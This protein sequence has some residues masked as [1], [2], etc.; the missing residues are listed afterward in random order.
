MKKCSKNKLNINMAN[1]IRLLVFFVCLASILL[2]VNSIFKFKYTDGISQLS[3]F[4]RQDRNSIDVLILGS[5]HSFV[6]CN[7]GTLYE[8]YGIASYNMG[9]SMQPMW[10]SYYNLIEALKTQKPE[11]I[12]LE[13]HGITF[14]FD[15][16]YTSAAIKNIY[17]MKWSLNKVRDILTSVDSD[18]RFDFIL[19]YS[20][21]H[22][23]YSSLNKGDFIDGFGD[24]ELEYAYNWYGDS[25]KGQYLF[26]TSN[27]IEIEDVSDVDGV[28][29]LSSKSEM[30]YRKIIELAK[31][32]DITVDVF[33]MS[34]NIWFEW[35][36]IIGLIVSILIFGEYGPTFDPKQFIYFQF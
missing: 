6:N 5:S 17:G 32:N 33:L 27:P 13:G 35:A 8:E 10:N 24:S 16:L 26:N 21:Y 12:V 31:E 3:N 4:Y 28:I 18:H 25:W 29:D 9:G 34:Q 20:Q 7:N 19:E 23:R 1:I 22:T 11:L 36:C 14:D 2:Y 30:Y 15:Y